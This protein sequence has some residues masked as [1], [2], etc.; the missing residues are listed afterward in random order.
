ML[1]EVMEHFGLVKEFR[2]ARYYETEQQ[3]Q[4]FKDIKAQKC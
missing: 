1:A 2:R 4:M 3:K